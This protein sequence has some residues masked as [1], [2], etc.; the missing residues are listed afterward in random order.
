MEDANLN[1]HSGGGDMISFF[2]IVGLVV[3]SIL[4]VIWSMGD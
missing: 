2:L 4:L 3:I 1:F